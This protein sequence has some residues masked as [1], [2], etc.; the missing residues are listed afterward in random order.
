MSQEWPVSRNSECHG[1]SQ[2]AASAASCGICSGQLGRSRAR[3]RFQRDGSRATEETRA[4]APLLGNVS[5]SP[6]HSL[7]RAS[8]RLS[9][10][11]GNLRCA[12]EHF[13]LHSCRET[14][15]IDAYF[16]RAGAHFLSAAQSS[17]LA[18]LFLNTKATC[19]VDDTSVR[20]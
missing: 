11:G 15:R 16:C 14:C 12:V 4:K 20:R 13:G 19:V 10:L 18:L 8:L 1:N 17:Y 7:G 2:C 6:S 9:K 3:R 5:Q